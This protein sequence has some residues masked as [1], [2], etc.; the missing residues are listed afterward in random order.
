MNIPFFLFQGVGAAFLTRHSVATGSKVYLHIKKNR[1]AK[2]VDEN[3]LVGIDKELKPLFLLNLTSCAMSK[4]FVNRYRTR[5]TNF[6]KLLY[7]TTNSTSL[8]IS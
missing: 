2:P 6:F 1:V 7:L 8:K 3:T 4:M 5:W